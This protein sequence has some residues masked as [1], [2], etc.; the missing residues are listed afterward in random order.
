MKVNL[1]LQNGIVYVSLTLKRERLRYSTGLHLTEVVWNDGD[2]KPKTEPERAVVSK[3]TH[4]KDRCTILC[5]QEGMT[6]PG[7]IAEMDR[8]LEKTKPTGT[9][10]HDFVAGYLERFKQSRPDSSWGN[11]ISLLSNLKQVPVELEKVDEAYYNRLVQYMVSKNRT[12][13][14]QSQLIS[15]VK[16]VLKEANKLGLW[17]GR[18]DFTI[19]REKVYNI[20]L[21]MDEVVSIYRLIPTLDDELRNIADQ[22]VIGC[23]TGLRYSDFSRINL[24]HVDGFITMDTKKTQQR[25]VIPISPMVRDCLSRSHSIVKNKLFNTKLRIIVK[26]AGITGNFQKTT[27]RGNERVTKTY[28]RSD[29]VYTHTARRTAA[30][31]M[32]KMHVPSELI[33]KITGHRST[34]SFREYL[35]I[36]EMEAAR[37]L[38]DHEFFK[39]SV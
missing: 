38:A 23:L 10:L 36:D 18:F 6:V 21:T 5:L 20:A 34:A 2:M 39:G 14:T 16:I 8:I 4:L 17:S 7:L 13:N 31:L 15:M 25:V 24:N 1:F 9:M 30:T 33:M 29:L 37:L 32:F 12:R 28:D 27:T 22:F 19:K 26:Q 3:V 11:Y 35:K